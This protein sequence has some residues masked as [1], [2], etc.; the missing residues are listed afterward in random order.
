MVLLLT[1][2][3]LLWFW[4]GQTLAPGWRSVCHSYASAYMEVHKIN[5][6]LLLLLYCLPM[7]AAPV[8]EFWHCRWCCCIYVVECIYFQ[9]IY[10]FVFVLMLLLVCCVV[11]SDVTR[12]SRCGFGHLA[13][14]PACVRFACTVEFLLALLHYTIYKYSYRSAYR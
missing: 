11:S 3:L 14:W 1:S 7:A 8:M 4:V 6:L 13:V 5:R 12:L 10:F 2:L 9:P